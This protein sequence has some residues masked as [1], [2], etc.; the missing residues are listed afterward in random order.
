MTALVHRRCLNHAE[1]EAVARCPE[2]HGYFCRECISEHDERMLCSACLIKL[3]ARAHP[4]RRNF[5]GLF[6]AL[7]GAAA[8]AAIWFFF[9]L[10]SRAM[11]AV[12]ASFHAGLHWQVEHR[13]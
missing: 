4:G 1:R 12:P 2:C 9:F 13:E 7:Q 10:V 5:G 3:A 11:L 8:L 6:L